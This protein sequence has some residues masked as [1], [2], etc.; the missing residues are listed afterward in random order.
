MTVDVIIE[1]ERWDAAGLSDLAERA[2]VATL[3]HAGVDPEAWEVVVLGCDD[4]RI[5][6]LNADFREAPNPT[7]VLSWPTVERGAATAGQPPVP[8]TGERELGDIAL[9]FETCTR[10]AAEQGKT[11]EQHFLHLIV[12][13]VLHLL[14][15]DHEHEGDGDLMESQEIAILAGLGVPNPYK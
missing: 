12:H 4:A 11:P 6:A 5:A 14:G 7:N 15:Y 9:A 13:G 10:E 3:D 8:P 1:D 2:V